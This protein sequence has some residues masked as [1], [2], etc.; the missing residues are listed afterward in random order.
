MRRQLLDPPGTLDV[1][2]I[3]RRLSGVQAQVSSSA[4]LAIALRQ[5][6]PLRGAVDEALGEGRLMRSWAMRG[7]LHLLAPDDASAYLVLIG[8]ARTWER[9]AW[10]RALGITEA[11]MAAL[12]E[13]VPAALD[14]RVLD[15]EELIE[16][17]AARTGSRHL[18]VQLRSGWG[19]V[20]KPLAW[21][22][23]LCNGPSRGGRVTFTRPDT[24]LPGWRGMPELEQA[25]RIV[26]PAYLR[27]H[28][29]ATVKAFDAW[30]MRG[31]SR[32]RDL[33]RWFAA[34]EDLLVEVDVGGERCLALTE[35][36]DELVDAAPSDSVRLLA[37]FDQYLLGP[38]TG[39]PHILAPARRKAVSKAAG[40]IAPVVIKGG[41]VAGCWELDGDT[42]A[43]RLFP[44][45]GE[46]SPDA[47]AAEAVHVGDFLGRELRVAVQSA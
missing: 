44:E 1:V 15:R 9:P 21:M 25:A 7:T 45:A 36:L 19:A 22:G 3:T 12:V 37:G 26:I 30:L 13:A 41:R 11:D 29:P 46:V 10:R 40:W 4:E 42:L 18:E 8:A 38:G 28:G 39:D 20:L 24:W 34:V 33:R 27:A 31:A 6:A 16:E 5:R 47:L 23:L 32:T 35:D 43:V 2:A 14:G 17:I